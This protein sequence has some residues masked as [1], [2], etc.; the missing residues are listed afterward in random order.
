MMMTSIIAGLISILTPFISTENVVDRYDDKPALSQNELSTI[1]D[2]EVT[3][4]SNDSYTRQGVSIQNDLPI[5]GSLDLPKS[6]CD[7]LH[8]RTLIGDQKPR[9]AG[10]YGEPCQVT[11]LTLS[12]VLRDSDSPDIAVNSECG[13]REDSVVSQT[14]TGLV[15]NQRIRLLTHD[16]LDPFYKE[17]TIRYCCR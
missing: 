1:S 15:P 17:P 3:D 9:S 8:E 6:D 11:E 5:F 7:S 4:K 10:H 16:A 13:D 14:S 12:S 2:I